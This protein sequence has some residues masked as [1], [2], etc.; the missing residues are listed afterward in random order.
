MRKKLLTLFM[1]VVLLLSNSSIA[2]AAE[3]LSEP[4]EM[5][6]AIPTATGAQTIAALNDSNSVVID[7]RAASDYNAAHIKG[8]I[9]L[10]V[11]LSDFSVTTEQRDNFVNYVKNNIDSS[12]KVY[13]VCYVGTFCVNF[14]AKW[15]TDPVDS[16]GCGFSTDNIYRVTGGVW[17]DADLAAACNS[18]HYDYAL[19]ADGIIL[20][21]RAT[22]T[23]LNGYVD[24]S[25][26]QPLFDDNGVTSGSDTLATDFT[27]FI[28]ANKALLSSKNIYVLC[29]SGARGALA[30]I[31]LFAAEGIKNVF[32][33]E[34]GAKSDIKNSF[35]TNK[36]VDAEAAVNAVGS[37]DVVII[38]VRTSE[39]Y[40]A[41]HLA[42]SLSMPLFDANGVTSGSDALAMNFLKSVQANAETLAG[43]DLYILCNSGSKGAQ[44]AT[45]LLMQAG[46]SSTDVF[47]ITGGAGTD[48]VKNAFVTDVTE[49]KF[50][51]GSD[52]VSADPEKTFIIDV[53]TEANYNKGHLANSVNWPLFNANGV[54]NKIDALAKAFTANVK[55]NEAE[56][57]GKDIYILCNS[58]ARGAQAA[59]QLLADAGYNVSTTEDGKVYT[60]KNG[61]TD[62]TVRYNFIDS[63]DI[64]TVTGEETVE[65]VGK[66]GYIILDVRASGNY[67]SGHLKGSVSLPVFTSA[68]PVATTKDELSVA[69][70]N[71]V[72]ENKATLAA[73]KI[74]ILC[75]S[76]SRGAQAATVLLNDAG[77]NLDNVYTVTGGYNKNE[78]IQEAATYV[79]PTHAINKLNDKNYVIIDVRSADKYA[80]GHLEGS[81]SLPLFDK[82]NNLPDD[83]AKAFSDYV[84]ANKAAF[85]GKTIL[86]LC[87]SGS[88]GAVKATE[89]LEAEGLT[90]VFTIENG[91]KSDIIQKN[92]VTNDSEADTNKKPN[93]TPD[94]G[95][96]SNAMLYVLVMGISLLAVITVSKKKF[97]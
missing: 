65:A 58:G 30:A 68:G 45:K 25:L 70:T 11:C 72:N 46:Y 6:N 75:N 96:T 24:K 83:L 41:G 3:S 2:F 67:A 7:L 27:A 28:N 90:K 78:S 37:N 81:L 48:T 42:G 10:P 71:Y 69:F 21:V 13:L 17:N 85:E 51:S 74:Y 77:I 50:V 54:T 60:I 63:A 36:S 80:A 73:S 26:H 38:D 47:T 23:Y 82:D 29:N 35:I 14:A 61:A 84:K 57:A 15:L 49:F 93:G 5:A 55:A 56:L 12:K 22:S 62:M 92:F 59:T 43:K 86:V 89:L 32:V 88:R 33:I 39:K 1:A 20:D 52:A 34:N 40:A 64:H 31:D 91:A 94:T 18:A 44:A 8:S 87:N 19:A 53:R 95:D 9:S 66:E 79:S 16:N 4:T 76:G 97:A